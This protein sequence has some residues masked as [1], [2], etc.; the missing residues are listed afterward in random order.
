VHLFCSHVVFLLW[1]KNW[2]LW[3]K[4]QSERTAALF[5]WRV[6]NHR[7][8]LAVFSP[9]ESTRTWEQRTND[10]RWSN[11]TICQHV[12][13]INQRGAMLYPPCAALP[14]HAALETPGNPPHLIHILHPHKT[15]SRPS[16]NAMCTFRLKIVFF[17]HMPIVSKLI[18]CILYILVMYE[19]WKSCII[20]LF[21]YYLK[22][23][24]SLYQMKHLAA[25]LWICGKKYV[26]SQNI[27][28]D[29]IQIMLTLGQHINLP[30]VAQSQH[31][32]IA[33]NRVH[34]LFDYV[35]FV[36]WRCNIWS[37]L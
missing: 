24:L 25:F 35:T 1:G 27:I 17:M 20:A 32:I 13:N 4:Q 12:E 2:N 37:R 3:R 8:Q 34:H 31:I 29:H 9:T 14:P 30:N 23:I 16:S 5:G 18:K 33:V 19:S 22:N 26:M 36:I 15:F 11:K 7:L 10:G 6:F 28:F 21:P